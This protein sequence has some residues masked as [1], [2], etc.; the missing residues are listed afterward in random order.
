[1]F[2]GKQKFLR[3]GFRELWREYVKSWCKNV[4]PCT[5]T[6]FLECCAPTS[7]GSCKTTSSALKSFTANTPVAPFLLHHSQKG[8]RRYS[9][10]KTLNPKKYGRQNPTYCGMSTK[11]STHTIHFKQI[12]KNDN[13][14]QPQQRAK[15]I[16]H[17]C[18]SLLRCTG[19]AGLVPILM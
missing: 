2:R 4:C 1:M 14:H 13:T 7:M 18:P 5:L 6:L 16:T 8:L 19:L 10:P 17:L 9:C 11:S 3:S 15:K 12:T